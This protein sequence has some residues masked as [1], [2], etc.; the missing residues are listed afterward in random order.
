MAEVIQKGIDVASEYIWGSALD[1]SVSPEICVASLPYL[2]SNCLSILVTK[3]IGC[4]IIFGAFMNKAPIFFNIYKTQS[5]AGISM[6]SVYAESIMY[7]N[8]AFYGILRGNPFTSWGENGIVTIQTLGVVIMLWKYKSDPAISMTQRIMA[9]ILYVAYA[10]SVFTFL[11]PHQYHYLHMCNWGALLYAR[12]SQIV[13]TMFVKHTG[14]QSILTIFMNMSGT[15]V[16]IFTT[17]K[18]VGW[19]FALLSGYLL[20]AGLNAMLVIQYFYYRKNTEIFLKSL[21]KKVA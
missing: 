7:S 8:A 2:Q 3:M 18:E 21:K 5:G 6:G 9:L 11:E 4:V 15:V 10:T 1:E 17:L 12:G 16:R 13:S 20:S 14:N 19:D